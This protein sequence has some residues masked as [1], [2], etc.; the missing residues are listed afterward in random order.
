VTT[1]ES[2]LLYVLQ[3]FM[4]VFYLLHWQKEVLGEYCDWLSEVLASSP[5]KPQVKVEM[6]GAL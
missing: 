1:W 5:T 3:F 6:L 4:N 2:L